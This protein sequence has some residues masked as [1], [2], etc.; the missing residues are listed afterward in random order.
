MWRA[1]VY[2]GCKGTETG[3][4][5]MRDAVIPESWKLSFICVCVCVCTLV[6]HWSEYVVHVCVIQS[7][8]RVQFDGT[9]GPVG[10]TVIWDVPEGETDDGAQTPRSTIT[11]A[12]DEI[13]QA[14]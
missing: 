11:G 10:T 6:S 12:P 5:G 13:T 3:G 7:A 14:S 1:R 4:M 2:V 9:V 8:V